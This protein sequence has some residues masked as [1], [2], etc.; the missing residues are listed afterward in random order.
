MRP[1]CSKIFALCAQAETACGLALNWGAEKF[2]RN[3][4]ISAIILGNDR[5]VRVA[6]RLGGRHARDENLHGARA[7]IYAY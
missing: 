5:S 1:W 2:G 6:E 4:I 7:M 3:A